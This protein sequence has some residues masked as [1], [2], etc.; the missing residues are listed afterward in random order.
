MRRTSKLS[1]EELEERK[2]KRKLYMRSYRA[3]ESEKS[4]EEKFV[5]SKCGNMQLKYEPQSQ[6]M[7]EKFVCNKC[8]NV[9]LKFEPQSQNT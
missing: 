3:K 9:Q 2:K 6:N 7:S 4:R 1:S 5:C 8:G